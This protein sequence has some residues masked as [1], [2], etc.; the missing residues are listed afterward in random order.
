MAEHPGVVFK[1]GPT[2]RRAALSFGPDGWEVVR[3]LA[4]IDERGQDALEATAEV[5]SLPP[6]KVRVALHYY[7]AFSEEIDAEIEQAEDESAAAEA[8]FMAEQRLLA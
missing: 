6:A 4:E 1:D 5:M 2:G 7:S 8:A 3:V